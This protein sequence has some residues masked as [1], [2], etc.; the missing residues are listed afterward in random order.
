MSNPRVSVGLPV[1]NGE[2]Y[3]AQAIDSVLGQTCADLELIISDNASTDSTQEICQRYAAR[4]P[5]VR[6]YRS[7]TNRGA[8]ANYNRVFELARGEYFQWLAH[9][10][11][12]A[13]EFAKQCVSALDENPTAVLCFSWVKVIDEHGEQTAAGAFDLK[14][15]AH[16]PHVRFREILL[17][18]HNS[19]FVFGLI[20]ASALRETKLIQPLAHGDTLLIARLSLMGRFLGIPDYLFMSRN[21]PEQS[22]RVYKADLPRGLDLAAYTS[23]YDAQAARNLR[24]P[25]W[26][27][28]AEF[29][30]TMWGIDLK[31]LDR[32]ACHIS[33][34][35]LAFRYAHGLLW[36]LGGPA[37]QLV[38][39]F[40][41]ALRHKDYNTGQA[42]RQAD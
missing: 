21:H 2:K 37:R 12:L 5:R 28:M 42:A 14:V 3:V 39:L 23:W 15:D 27:L 9:D 1:Y 32:L 7:D 41:F 35:R 26:R 20:R 16:E 19:L 13:P 6:Y 24:H 11:L 29:Y 38:R 31:M 34:A 25:Y 8:S 40:S 36:D 33:F 17:G 10:D 18:W 30:R 4:D 22:N